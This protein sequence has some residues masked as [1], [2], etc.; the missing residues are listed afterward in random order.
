MS[1]GVVCAKISSRYTYRSSQVTLTEAWRWRVPDGRV[2]KKTGDWHHAE[3]APIAHMD[4]EH[5]DSSRLQAELVC[6]GTSHM[7][8]LGVGKVDTHQ[9]SKSG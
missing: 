4:P 2:V 6:H 5:A 7:R 1:G 9:T 8:V 3:S